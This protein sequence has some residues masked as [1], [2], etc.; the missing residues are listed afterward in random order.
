MCISEATNSRHE[1][2]LLVLKHLNIRK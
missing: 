2:H 1:W